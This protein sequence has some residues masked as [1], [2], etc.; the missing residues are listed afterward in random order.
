[1]RG[2]ALEIVQ[3]QPGAAPQY[4]VTAK[5]VTT[6]CSTII[7]SW[8]PPETLECEAPEEDIF[9]MQLNYVPY[10]GPSTS[11]LNSTTGSLRCRVLPYVLV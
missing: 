6:H 11:S 10:S 3:T 4:S 9:N 8:S 5:P 2:F 7:E 1:M